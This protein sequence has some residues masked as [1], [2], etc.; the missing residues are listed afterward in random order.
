MKKVYIT[1]LL[2]TLELELEGVL[3][4]STGFS[5]EDANDPAKARL[6]DDNDWLE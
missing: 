3:A 2:E 1:P 5:D 4:Y 6:I